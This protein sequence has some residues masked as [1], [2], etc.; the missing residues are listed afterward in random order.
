MINVWAFWWDQG[1]SGHFF[2]FLFFLVTLYNRLTLV[3]HERCIDN[4]LCPLPPPRPP[5]ISPSDFS[6]GES[7]DKLVWLIDWMIYSI[8]R[9]RLIIELSSKRERH[10]VYGPAHWLGSSRARLLDM[11]LRAMIVRTILISLP[12]RYLEK[13][14]RKT[15]SRLLGVSEVCWYL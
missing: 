4:F 13:K 7:G 5:F 15:E 9:A 8:G 3:I 14:E 12:P 2:F 1:R 11:Q 10:R 6:L